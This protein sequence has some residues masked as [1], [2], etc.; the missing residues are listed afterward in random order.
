MVILLKILVFGIGGMLGHKVYQTFKNKNYE[1]T[2][3][4]RDKIKNYSSIDLFKKNDVIENLNII[5]F[6]KLRNL[7][8]DLKPN[9]IINCIAEISH[10]TIK[11]QSEMILI[12]SV[13]P[14]KLSEFAEDFDGRI[15]QISTDGVFSGK[16]GNYS[17]ESIPD[18]TDFYGRTKLLGEVI[19]NNSL[20]IRTAVIGREIKHKRSLIE[21]IISQKNKCV[22]GYVNAFF[23]GITN[24]E[25]SNLLVEFAQRDD[26]NGLLNVG[27]EKINKY[28]LINLVNEIY[29]LDI[30]T[31]VY[32]EFYCDRTLNLS[33][34]L[35]LGFKIKPIKNMI[36]EM[37]EENFYNHII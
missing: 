11:K 20:T 17:E 30:T 5:N 37:S 3:T 8:T 16:K 32:E 1:I 26:I 25:L 23:N 33:K 10:K 18:A 24:V 35:K 12:N 2:G 27:G 31:N 34:F 22:N 6:K 7:L 4:L 21:W 36:V 9:L 14:Q 29:N 19:N 28:E 13:F 15:I